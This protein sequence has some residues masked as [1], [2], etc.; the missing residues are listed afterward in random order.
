LFRD[1]ATVIRRHFVGR[2]N[3]PYSCTAGVMNRRSSILPCL[4]ARLACIRSASGIRLALNIGLS[5]LCAL[6]RDGRRHAR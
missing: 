2:K 4:V 5:R 1:R 6:D 3:R